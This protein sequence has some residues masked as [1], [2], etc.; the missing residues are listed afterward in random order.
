[1]GNTCYFSLR[2]LAAASQI[3]RLETSNGVVNLFWKS[4]MGARELLEKLR[5]LKYQIKRVEFEVCAVEDMLEQVC[6]Q[7]SVFAVATMVNYYVGYK[8]PVVARIADYYHEQD[9]RWE[10]AVWEEIS[11]AFS[12]GFA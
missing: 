1:M 4:G 3:D 10:A 11:K 5:M 2:E 7:N 6:R 12:P 9:L 8:N